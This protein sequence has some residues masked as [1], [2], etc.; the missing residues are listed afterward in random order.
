MKKLTVVMISFIL[1]LL[2]GCSSNNI[3]VKLSTPKTFTP[4]KAIALQIKV[5]DQDGKSIKG[6]KVNAKLSMKNMDHGTFPMTFDEVENGRYIGPADLP[7]DGDWVADIT[8]DQDGKKSEFEKEFSIQTRSL[9]NAH[10]V[11]KKVALPDFNLIDESGKPVTK[12]NLLG[13]RVALT[14]TYVNCVDPNACPVLLGNFSKLQQDLK[15]NGVNT[16]DILLVSV[17]IDP[18]NDTPEKL[19]EHAE[20]MNF[21]LSY[22][23]MLTGDLN[24]VNKL[25]GA[26][27]E[28]F[29]KKGNEVIHDNKT[30]IFDQN[31]NL[32]H[33][34]TGSMV[35]RQELFHIVAGGK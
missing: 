23:E 18:E 8:V 20:K 31:G 32:T 27:G 28:H 14:F 13:K 16:D 15:A 11:T 10:K 35:D 19:M 21:D 4:G 22:L 29:E 33:E 34:F 26:L 12:Q 17:S 30:F 2:A 25:T 6:A 9:D 1:I 24:E 3:Q 5:T 7:M